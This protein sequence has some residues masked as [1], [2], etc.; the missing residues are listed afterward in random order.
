[1]NHRNNDVDFAVS[2]QLYSYTNIQLLP[3]SNF[4]FLSRIKRYRTLR[5]SY[6][7]MRQRLTLI[8]CAKYS[9]R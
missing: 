4:L 6:R 1:M 5:K 7:V 9:T 8:A 2:Q 3:L